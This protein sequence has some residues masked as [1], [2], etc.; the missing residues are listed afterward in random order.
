MKKTVFANDFLESFRS[1]GPP[2]LKTVIDPG[3]DPSLQWLKR[4]EERGLIANE[5]F[6]GNF[7]RRAI[8]LFDVVFSA[9]ALILLSPLFL[10]LAIIIRIESPG[11]VIYKQVRTGLNLR[12]GSR[13]LSDNISV[14]SERRGSD[15][16]HGGAPGR[17]F[18]IY[19]FRSMVSD[20]E[21]NGIQLAKKKRRPHNPPRQADAPDASRRASSVLE[22]ADGPHEHRGTPARASGDHRLS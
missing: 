7:T 12:T 1:E 21:K 4:H 6:L 11:P 20:A 19:K 5:R 8:R 22:C 18:E 10:L 14:M 17:P 9:I 16:R 13:R 2:K 15:R 3:A